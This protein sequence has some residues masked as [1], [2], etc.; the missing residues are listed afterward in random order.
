MPSRKI[1][2]FS[3]QTRKIAAKS[4]TGKCGKRCNTKVT[5]LIEEMSD[6]LRLSLAKPLPSSD[7]QVLVSELNT[8]RL[9]AE[10]SQ[11]KYM[12]MCHRGVMCD[13]KIAPFSFDNG[14]LCLC[15]MKTNEPIKQNGAEFPYVIAEGTPF[16]RGRIVGEQLKDRILAF[17]TLK[18]KQYKGYMSQW[19]TYAKRMIPLMQKYTPTA[20]EEMRGMASVQGLNEDIVFRLAT[21]YDFGGSLAEMHGNE[22]TGSLPKREHCTGFAIQPSDVTKPTLAG[23]TDDEDPQ[24]FGQ[25][26]SIVSYKGLDTNAL[27]YTHAGMPAYFGVNDHGLA[28]SWETLWYDEP[29]NL[30]TGVPTVPMI[31]EMLT[32]RNIED[33][34]HLFQSVPHPASNNFLISQNGK[35]IYN[36]EASPKKTTVVHKPIGTL[37][38]ANHAMFDDKVAA[39]D[40]N[41][42]PNSTTRGRYTELMRRIHDNSTLDEIERAYLHKPIINRSTIAGILMDTQHGT[43]DIFYPYKKRYTLRD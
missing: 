15:E 34:V 8:V 23:Q 41:E 12:K 20:F 5:R 17:D 24:W 22:F 3:L 1:A 6:E 43:L 27:V 19:S 14:N 28:I 31:R 35:G 37:V 16:Q 10:Q 9:A 13:P 42:L 26:P 36:L 32:K 38:H 29:F 7:L 2:K 21:E 33:A 39:K 4:T 30:K 11:Q 18:Q 40:A 25:S